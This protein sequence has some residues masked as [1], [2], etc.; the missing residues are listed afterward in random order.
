MSEPTVSEPYKRG[1]K[2]YDEEINNYEEYNINYD[3]PEE[4]HLTPP[5]LPSIHNNV[6]NINDAINE[7]INENN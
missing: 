7:T 3:E 1:G 5:K 4:L 6:N 2:Q